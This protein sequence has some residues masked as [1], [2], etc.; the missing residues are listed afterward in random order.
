MSQSKLAVGYVRCSTEMQEDSPEQQ[1]KEILSFAQRLGLK[2]VEW[3]T[4]FGKSGT[5]FDQRA[6]FQRLRRVVENNPV[7][8]TVISYDE[9]R[10]GRAI[11][12]EENAYWRVHFR[13]YGVEVIL[14]KTTIDPKHEFAP[15]MKAFEG[16]QAS[17]FSKKLSELTLRGAKNNG[18][19]SSG[20]TAPYGFK[21]IAVNTKTGTERTLQ[22]GEWCV[23]GQEKVRWGVGDERE[24]R[25][26]KEI[27]HKRA[28]GTACILIADSLNRR[29]ISCP[30]RGRWRNK[31]RKWSQVTIKSIIENPSYYGARIYNRNSMSKIQASH[32]GRDLRS[33]LR[34]PHW[35][36]SREK[37]VITESAHEA[38]ISKTLWDKANLVNRH[39]SGK[40]TEVPHKSQYLLS[41]LIKCP[42]CGFSYQGCTTRSKGRSYHRYVDGGWHNKRVCSSFSILKEP[43]ERFAVN[44]IR[45]VLCD[46]KLA[47]RLETTLQALLKARP[48]GMK[49]R[50]N[51]LEKELAG[52]EDKIS[53]LT[54]AIEAGANL[55]P[56][57]NRLR[58]LENR[59]GEIRGTL[60]KIHP[61]QSSVPDLAEI[62]RRVSAMLLNF[63][64]RFEK[65]PIE[66]RKLVVRKLISQVVIDR[67]QRVARLYVR[68]L[69]AVT[70]EL[71]S[72]YENKRALTDVVS[73]RS[74]GGRT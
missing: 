43:L 67:D 3:Y 49:N 8:S 4:D 20:G 26:V 2:I 61:I 7:F 23:A 44:A 25:V 64:D 38:I 54:E 71:E 18:I 58:E 39:H 65:A 47:L 1:Q 6:E 9:S 40:R 63:Q 74:S 62:K 56:I 27:F 53:K 73:A 17:Q 46:P 32:D 41:G 16:V 48:T 5:T 59:K 60:E 21:R 55:E 66:E 36:N 52:C 68:K 50:V 42:I 13:R 72:L 14:V 31:D 12:A 29:R 28:L 22:D 34:Y 57:L 70:P 30:K 11:D 24:V 35:K 33:G 37:W 15:M 69:P 51:D 45:D 10:W 19:Y